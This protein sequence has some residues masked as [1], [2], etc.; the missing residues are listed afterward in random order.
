[1]LTSLNIK[2]FRGI[3]ELTLKPLGRINLVGGKNGV[4][5]T[6]VLEA[7]WCLSGPDLPQLAV[8]ID[9]F[10]G[11][12]PPTGDTVFLDLFHGFDTDQRIE[13]SGTVKGHLG[14]KRLRMSL[15]ERPSSI[16]RP[17]G[18][19]GTS[20]AEFERSTQT[21]SEGQ[22]ELVFDYQHEDGREYKSRGWWVEQVIAP[23]PPGPV[24]VEITNAGVREEKARV[25]KRADSVFMASPYRENLQ[26]DAQRFGNL[27]IQG[28]DGEILPLLKLIEPRLEHLTPILINN[29]PVIHADL[30]LGRPIAARLLGEGFSRLL[31]IALAMYTARGGLLLIDEIENGLHHSTLTDLFSMVYEMATELDVQVIA[32]THSAE[33]I[34]AAFRSLARPNEKERFAFHRIDRVD[35]LSEAIHFDQDAL[36][37]ALT[38]E[39]EVR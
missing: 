15:L 29:T 6:S 32:A 8:R 27:Q 26:A 20:E 30:G 23:A 14:A 36:E 9:S 17:F 5:K 33:C 28:K 4:G 39:M 18:F 21:A 13:V 10:R 38:Y 37:T 31:S 35:G 34:E 12:P 2:N 1:M 7:S 22:F 25:P 16:V 19:R 11:L 3:K 24:P